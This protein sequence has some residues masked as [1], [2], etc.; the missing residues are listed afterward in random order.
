MHVSAPAD[1]LNT[2]AW[3]KLDRTADGRV[4]PLVDH[5]LDVAAVVRRLL[6]IANIRKRLARLGGRDEL[7]PLDVERLSALA[8]LHDVGKCSLGFQSKSLSAQVRTELLRRAGG[9]WHECGHTT[10]AMPFFARD[11]RD[12]RARDLRDAIGVDRLFDWGE[13]SAFELWLAAISHHGEPIRLVDLRRVEWTWRAA[14]DGSYDPLE[15][16]AEL[17]GVLDAAFGTAFIPGPELPDAAAFTHGFAGL[18]SLADWIGSN[19]KP[20]FFPYDL[21]PGIERTARA[22]ER[23]GMVLRRMRVDMSPARASSRVDTFEAV[24]GFSPRPLQIAAS[25]PELGPIVVVESETGSGKTEAAL[26]RF[27][28]LFER[29]EVDGLA[30]FLPTRVAA[31]QIHDR[32]QRCISK[33]FPEAQTRPNVVL[34]VPGYVRADGEDAIEMLPQF[35]V[36]WP[37]SGDPD[38]VAR[39]WAAEGIKRY[40]AA[41]VAVGTIDQLLLSGLRVSHSHLRAAALLR[42]LIVVDEVH[43]SDPYMAELLR[44]A[45][46]RHMA[47]G[48]HAMLLSATLG[49]ATRERLLSVGRR[50]SRPK[51]E[52]EPVPYPA[53]SDVKTLRPIV[54]VGPGKD[55]DVELSALAENPPELAARLFDAVAGGARILVIRNTVRLAHATQLA[56]EQRLAPEAATWFRAAEQIA[57]HHG[58]Y[59]AL[60]RVLLD[61]EVER[62]YGKNAPAGARLLVGTQSLEISL[63]CDADLLVTDLAP[64]DVLLQRIG[65]LH[66][67]ERVRPASCTR[68]RVVILTPETRDLS[69]HLRGGRLGF[70]PRS[71]YEN[72]LAVEATWCELERR[73]TLRIPYENRELVEAATDP[74]RLEALAHT[75]GG[76]WPDHW[77]ELIGRSAARGAAAHAVALHWST[78]WEDSG[79]GEL[80]ERIR[81]RLGLD[82]RRVR[83]S[84]RV[85]SP[86]GHDLDELQIPAVLWP[87][88]CDTEHAEVVTSDASATT[89]TLGGARLRYDRL[90]L[91]HEGA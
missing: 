39:R 79:F 23:A 83:L 9:A 8:F 35:E 17:K 11:P 78:S 75:L 29:G 13:Q 44:G 57:M 42:H 87:T 77:N 90:G 67:H 41:S 38:A 86:F 21:A 52:L 46:E 60:D 10:I 84:R 63:D 12:T 59:A 58:R 80:G 48:G 73:S 19:A 6:G 5:C 20:D 22:R 14:P 81:T 24:F 32:V 47:A 4:L 36:L 68:A 37:D 85:Q 50:P 27:R 54:A 18:V 64:I 71:P 61:R 43:A 91:R 40:F 74:M 69:A 89:I 33:L 31:T 70:G 49:N 82:T 30:F 51:P 7:S 28:T 56:L 55:V 72:V 66:R 76:A 15:A 1:R 65:R 3:G 16:I 45:L 26:W 62:F 25:D 53:I 88:G 2:R 34:A